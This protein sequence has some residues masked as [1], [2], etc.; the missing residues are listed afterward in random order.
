MTP[1]RSEEQLMSHGASEPSTPDVNNHPDLA[2]QSV[3]T[4]EILLDAKAILLSTPIPEKKPRNNLRLSCAIS[5]ID[6]LLEK[7]K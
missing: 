6:K 7:T 2:P 5:A 1:Y 3:E 4:R